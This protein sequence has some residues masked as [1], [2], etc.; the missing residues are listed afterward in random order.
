MR[1]MPNTV[2]RGKSAEQLAPELHTAENILATQ[3]FSFN[4]EARDQVRLEIF[5]LYSE[6]ERRGALE[7]QRQSRRPTRS[8]KTCRPAL[9]ATDSPARRKKGL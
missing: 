9:G 1:S 3:S 8:D 4:H 7:F 5:Q 6:P 2:L